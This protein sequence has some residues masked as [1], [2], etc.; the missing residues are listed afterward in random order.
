[1]GWGIFIA[2]AAETA[3]P[4]SFN[5]AVDAGRR[6]GEHVPPLLFHLDDLIGVLVGPRYE[7]VLG[8]Q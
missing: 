5:A 3:F 4:G 7:V 6:I 1:M 2:A 8:L